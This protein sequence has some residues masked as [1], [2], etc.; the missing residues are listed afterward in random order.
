VAVVGGGAVGVETALFLAEEG[1]MPADTLKFLLVNKA[2]SP[3]ALYEMATQGSKKI[4]LIE[5]TDKIGKDI[6]KSTKW[7]MMQ[8]MGRFG[9]GKYHCRQG[10]QDYRGWPGD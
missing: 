5:M 3:E 7:G 9:V 8:D 4:S 6:G 2:E 1:T 10:R